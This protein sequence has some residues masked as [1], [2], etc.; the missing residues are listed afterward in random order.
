MERAWP[1]LVRKES[2]PGPAEVRVIT[3]LLFLIMVKINFVSN[4]AY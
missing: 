3:K 1:E 4:G 2:K